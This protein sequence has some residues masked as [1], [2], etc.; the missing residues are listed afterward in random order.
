ME[1][2]NPGSLNHVEQIG[3]E[4]MQSPDSCVEDTG[5]FTVLGISVTHCD[6]W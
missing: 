3:G 4:E 1:V 6:L 2:S 5:K